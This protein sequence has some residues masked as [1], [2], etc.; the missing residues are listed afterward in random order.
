MVSTVM[1][2]CLPIGQFIK[3]SISVQFSLVTL[4]CTRLKS[5]LARSRTHVSSAA[6]VF[7]VFN[8]RTRARADVGA[9]DCQ[10]PGS[11]A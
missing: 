5:L 4:P 1:H 2:Y 10:V 8:Q 6:S 3:K 7:S 11:V 9:G